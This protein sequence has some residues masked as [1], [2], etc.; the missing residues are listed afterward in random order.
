M[1]S[2]QR[3]SLIAAFALLSTG[4]AGH[5]SLPSTQPDA[6]SRSQQIA[7]GPDQTTLTYIDLPAPYTFPWSFINAPDGSLYFGEWAASGGDGGIGRLNADGTI[8][9]TNLGSGGN[10]PM[11][12]AFDAAGNLWFSNCGG[13]DCSNNDS[14]DA[15]LA[16]GTVNS[17]AAAAGSRP[18]FS[19]I[20]AS[21][22]VWYTL[23]RADAVAR[24][25]PDGSIAQFPLP[26]L[27]FNR[28]APNDITVGPDGALWIV[29]WIGNAIVRMDLN[30][31]VTNVY[32]L[33]DVE[34]G[35][36]FIAAG[37]DGNLWFS[38]NGSEQL[39]GDPYT[40]PQIVKMTTSGQMTAYPMPSASSVPDSLRPANGGFVFADLGFNAVGFIDYNGNVSELP[41][42]YDGGQYGNTQFAIAGSDGS[43]YFADDDQSRIG[44]ITLGKKG[45]IFPQS[46]S[47]TV[48]GTQLVGVGV[49]GDRGPYTA[50]TD[51]TNV[52]TV[53]PIAGFPMN[54]TVTAVGP[55]TATLTIKGKGKAMTATVTVTAT[56]TNAR[57]RMSGARR[58]TV[59]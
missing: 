50:S 35:P 47:L 56:S 52:A 26:K 42:A 59:L 43:Y 6:A 10:S 48:D 39:N 37:S 29:E 46:F 34:A 58:V 3:L 8:S 12:G 7:G 17:L 38:E 23:A 20:D 53:A 13:F 51:N 44:K 15:L 40:P 28:A 36:R 19:A 18:R 5:G 55:G 31:T 4:C 54:F 30:G 16:N 21:G 33:P 24:V 11:L 27:A 57:R 41:I 49:L 32:A 1:R 9:E 22:N 25:S 2:F 14:F 45:I